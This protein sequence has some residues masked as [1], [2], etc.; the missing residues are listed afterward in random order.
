MATK[1]GTK[2]AAKM[3]TKMAAKMAAK[4]SRSNP[5]FVL[6]FVENILKKQNP[7]ASK[8]TCIIRQFLG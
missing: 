6:S 8:L 3:A 2:M 7:L 5:F 1:M 4:M